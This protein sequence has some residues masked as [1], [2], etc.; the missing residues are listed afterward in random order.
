M[1]L[2]VAAAMGGLD[3]IPKTCFPK[4]FHVKSHES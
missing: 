2:T 3:D 4:L 1:L